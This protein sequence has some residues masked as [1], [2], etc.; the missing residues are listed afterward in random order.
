VSGCAATQCG[1]YQRLAYIEPALVWMWPGVG[2]S[3]RS[4]GTGV[5]GSSD[6]SGLTS[7]CNSPN[8]DLMMRSD[9]PSERAVSGAPESTLTQH[10]SD[11][12]L[13]GHKQVPAFNPDIIRFAFGTYGWL[14]A[15]RYNARPLPVGA[16]ATVD[17]G[18]RQSNDSDDSPGRA[19]SKWTLRSCRSREIRSVSTEPFTRPDQ[20]D[21]IRSAGRGD[22]AR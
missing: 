17:P 21:A 19:A 12:V 16:D 8:S 13:Y 6:V 2:A 10:K 11:V 22:S 15:I 9:L 1:G 3:T 4:D 20:A 7:L 5:G 14:K 18:I